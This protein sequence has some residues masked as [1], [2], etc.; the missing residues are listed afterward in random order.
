MASCCP[1][2]SVYCVSDVFCGSLINLTLTALLGR[3]RGLSICH[4]N[5]T[6]FQSKK[7]TQPGTVKKCFKRVSAWNCT[8]RRYCGRNCSRNRISGPI[9]GT[10]TVELLI[11]GF[12]TGFA[13]VNP[14]AANLA[15]QVL[16]PN[17]GPHGPF[18]GPFWPLQP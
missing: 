1:A 7:S 17:S 6:W 12:S 13:A 4:V 14:V 3:L 16:L 5:V 15:P 10:Q 11:A 9:K 18:S 2:Y 8:R